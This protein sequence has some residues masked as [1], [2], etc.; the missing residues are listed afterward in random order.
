[1]GES[2]A[3]LLAEVSAIGRAGAAQLSFGFD[4]PDV[5]A[6]PP[7]QRLDWERSILGQPVSVHPLELAAGAAPA[8]GARR[9]TPLRELRGTV[10]RQGVIAGV[11]L[12]GWTGGPGYY[13]GD[14]DSFVLVR[15]AERPEPWEPVLL[16]GRWQ[17]DATGSSWFQAAEWTRWTADQSA[18]C[19]PFVTQC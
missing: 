8:D 16:R 5:K 9:L 10:G 19:H 1:L 13:L 6:E 12:P 17:Q 4:R 3:H 15:S 11:R 18:S 2:R 7:Q 14:G